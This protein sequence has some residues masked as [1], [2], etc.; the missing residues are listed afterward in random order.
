MVVAVHWGA[1]HHGLLVMVHDR[2]LLRHHHL[3]LL[4]LHHGLRRLRL[5]HRHLHVKGLAG[6]DA[7]RHV[8]L[9]GPAGDLHLD[10]LPRLHARRH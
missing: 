6:R 4:L 1:D 5:R 3:L 8:D 9:V 7:G 2:L 10:G